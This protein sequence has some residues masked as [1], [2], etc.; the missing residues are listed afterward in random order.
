MDSLVVECLQCGS[1]RFARRTVFRRFDCPEC[2][3]CGYVGWAPMLELTE[4]ERSELRELPVEQRRL[5][6][7]MA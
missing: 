4:G 5:V 1:T 7:T 6:S 2:P 3:R